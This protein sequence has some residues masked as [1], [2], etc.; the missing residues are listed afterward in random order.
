MKFDDFLNYNY[1][2]LLENYKKRYKHIFRTG[3]YEYCRVIHTANEKG[4]WIPRDYKTG[5]TFNKK[6]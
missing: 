6:G 2:R 3:F 4:M 5:I 1:D